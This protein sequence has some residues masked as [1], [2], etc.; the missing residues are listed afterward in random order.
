[1]SEDVTL[2]EFVK[3]ESDASETERDELARKTVCGIPPQ[4]W[5]IARLGEVVRVVSGNSLPTKY[6]NGN[7]GK[8]P[9]YKVSDM[10]ATGN[11]KYVSNSSNRLPEGEL[12]ELNHTL[13]PEGTTI[14]PK[15]GAALLTNKRRMLT[16]PSSFDNNVMGWVPDEINPE[17]L[18]YVSCM[19]DME[20]VAQKGAVP[21]ISK[22]IAKSLKLP[23]PPLSEQRKIATVLYTVD[24]A[25]EKTEETIEQSKKIGRGL[26]HSLFTE[27][28]YEHET[29]SYGT[30][31]EV[32]VSWEKTR[33]YKIADVARGKF[34]HRPRNDPNFY[35]G[36]Y[37]FIQTGEVVDA[38]GELT[39]FSQTLNEK[40]RGVSKEFA[41]GTII[42]TIA[43]NIGDTAVATFP[44]YFPDSLVGITPDEETDERFLEHFLRYRQ[45]FLNRLSTKTTQKNL[46]LTLLR[47]VE[48]VKPPLDEQK[49][50]ADV[51]ST[52]DNQ[53]K[54]EKEY[55]S[56]LQRLKHGLMQDLLSGTVRTTD[57]TIEVPDE[58][59][60]YG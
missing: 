39:D 16:E 7:K 42:I 40:G 1:M 46:N 19:I 21:S 4:D 14:L 48:V 25:I 8:H 26:R 54:K 20:A 24:Q 10:N 18:Y 44:V 51:L 37:P 56:H 22:A 3:Q 53:I 35:G 12:D 57:T 5:N 55:K 2:D 31:G 58:I 6:Q 36:E 47:P 28:Y 15:V 27:G 41:P 43:G 30:L 52:V 13:Y 59:K 50:I 49:E 11:Q 60:Q 29:E 17:F 32:P 38:V 45:D 9:V 23:S 34:T 33:L